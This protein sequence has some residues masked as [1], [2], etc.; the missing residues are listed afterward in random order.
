MTEDKTEAR[1]R[2]LET[3]VAVVKNEIKHVRDDISQFSAGVGRILWILGGSLLGAIV[4]WVVRGGL[5][6]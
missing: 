3:E 4:T 2:V 1:L 6:S 5:V